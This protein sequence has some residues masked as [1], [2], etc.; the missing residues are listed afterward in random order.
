MGLLLFL[1]NIVV[2]SELER[3]FVLTRSLRYNLIIIYSEYENEI[4]INR[5]N[6]ILRIEKSIENDELY[7][8]SP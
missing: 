2:K 8:Y 1:V 7:F 4:T 6:E 5:S 3:L